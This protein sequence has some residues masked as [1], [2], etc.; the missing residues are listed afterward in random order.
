MSPVDMSSPRDQRASSPR[1][2]GPSRHATGSDLS[3]ALIRETRRSLR[4]P[5][6]GPVIATGHVPANWH[7][8]I[9]AKFM[10]LRSLSRDTG[11]TPVVVTVDTVAEDLGRIDVPWIDADGLPVSNKIRIFE[12][13]NDRPLGMQPALT[14]PDPDW[15]EGIFGPQQPALAGLVGAIQRAQEDR[16]LASQLMRARL[17]LGRAWTGRP[18][19]IPA[20]RLLQTP[21][22]RW[23]IEAMERDTA[24]CIEAYNAAVS[25]DP[26]AGIPRLDPVVG[27]LPLWDV[28]GDGYRTVRRQDPATASLLPKALVTTAIMRLAGCDLFIHGTGGARYDALMEGWI[29]QWLGYE[30]APYM[31]MTT[32]LYL[33][34]PDLEEISRLGQELVSRGRRAYHDPESLEDTSSPG[35]RKRAA[36]ESIASAPRGSRERQVAYDSMHETLAS[37]RGQPREASVAIAERVRDARR[38][39]LRRDWDF[40]FYGTSALDQLAEE[41]ENAITGVSVLTTA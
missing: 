23:L 38:T 34:L 11:A 15:P 18:T 10:A 16:S 8:G 25:V 12:A 29:R 22:G 5:D 6:T 14:L 30:V 2:V 3:T 1:C 41:V 28:R 27:E 13:S 9:L 33:D 24:R 4:L 32:D 35:P 39:T 7:P 31:L 21:C 40:I 17:D 36:L 26:D 20:S 37:L 19:A